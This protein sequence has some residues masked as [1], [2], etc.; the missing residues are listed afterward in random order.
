VALLKPF[1]KSTVLFSSISPDYKKYLWDEL[2]SCVRFVGI[3]HNTLL[4]MPTYLRKIYI[5]KHNE[6]I[7]EENEKLKKA[8]KKRNK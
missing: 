2:I 6:H 4:K 5:G 1:L 8:G 3:D 7:K